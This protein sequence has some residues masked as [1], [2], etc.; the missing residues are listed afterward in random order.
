MPTDRVSVVSIACATGAASIS[1]ADTPSRR[2]PRLPIS[3]PLT[4]RKFMHVWPSWLARFPVEYTAMLH[5]GDL[6]RPDPK[7]T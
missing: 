1:R 7:R 5:R 3:G 6:P 4:K 2:L